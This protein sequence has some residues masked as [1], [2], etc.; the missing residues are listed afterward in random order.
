LK[1]PFDRFRFAKRRKF[2]LHPC[3]T[4]MPAL[5][6]AALIFTDGKFTA[7]NIKIAAKNVC[8]VKWKISS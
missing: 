5:P 6:S 1:K 2:G 7:A 3:R 4:A 8:A